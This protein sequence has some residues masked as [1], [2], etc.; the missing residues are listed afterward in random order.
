[1]KLKLIASLFFSFFCTVIF[2][3]SDIDS[4]T[5]IKIGD[6][7]PSFTT[8]SLAGTEF[9]S[10]ALTGKVVLI[11]FWATW[12]PPCKAEFPLLQKNIFDKIKDDSFSVLCI[13]RGEKK[14]VVN[15]FIKQ[16]GYT[17]PVYLDPE[18]KTYNLFASKYIP[19]NFVIGKDGKVKWA[20]TG[21]QL[22]EFNEMI[23]LIESEL[24]K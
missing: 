19:R 5:I 23:R 18:A 8:A 21:F 10:E 11:N 3:Q 9:S 15:K 16:F 13:S 14:E 20:S 24:K 22:E 1:M 17:F 2:S 6:K 12:C 7:L 4:T